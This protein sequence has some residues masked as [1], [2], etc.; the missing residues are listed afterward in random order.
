MTY[1]LSDQ[2]KTNR[3]QP[4][5]IRAM[6]LQRKLIDVLKH[7]H[8]IWLGSNL[9][10][11]LVCGCYQKMECL[12]TNC[13]CIHVAWHSHRL[14]VSFLVVSAPQPHS[15]C[16]LPLSISHL[17]SAASQPAHLQPVHRWSSS[18]TYPPAHQLFSMPVWYSQ[19]SNP[20]Y[21]FPHFGL[22]A[23]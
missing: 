3:W 13:M 1:I 18:R 10:N 4:G 19:N 16:L 14:A 12:S 17:P 8:T 6:R 11:I 7:G 20:V 15:R 21:I 23:C 22:C 2:M 5:M 9:Y